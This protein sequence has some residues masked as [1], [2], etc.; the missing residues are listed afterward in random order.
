MDSLKA[1]GIT[2]AMLG[3]YS[4]ALTG[5]HYALEKTPKMQSE[6]Y[7]LEQQVYDLHSKLLAADRRQAQC[8]NRLTEWHRYASL[9]QYRSDDMIR[10]RPE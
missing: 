1:I 2:L 9:Q 3:G 5:I 7:Q 10:R 8:M 4:G 6:I